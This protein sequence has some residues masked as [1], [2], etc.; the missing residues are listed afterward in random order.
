M[1]EYRGKDKQTGEWRYGYLFADDYIRHIDVDGIPWLR[2]VDPDTVGQSTGL[3]DRDGV[4]I[5]EGDKLECL[6]DS[7][8]V[9][10]NVYWDD[11]G[12]V[13][14][15]NHGYSPFLGEIA[16]PLYRKVV[17]NIHDKE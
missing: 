12:F 8:E 7:E 13:I 6:I 2:E 5:Y 9:V 11:G 16:T 17:G 15:G 14:D 4:T 3:P 10:S 1:R